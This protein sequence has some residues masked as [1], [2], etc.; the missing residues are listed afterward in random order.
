MVNIAFD[1]WN[2]AWLSCL[3]TNTDDTSSIW[4][5]NHQSSSRLR[6]CHGQIVILK[7]RLTDRSG[8][9]L[10]AAAN[11]AETVSLDCQWNR[12]CNHQ[13]QRQDH[14][15]WPPSSTTPPW[16]E[17]HRIGMANCHKGTGARCESSIVWRERII[18]STAEIIISYNPAPTD[19]VACN[20]SGADQA[21]N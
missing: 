14:H 18:L 21:I 11:C 3:H 7:H 9:W 16:C 2:T 17:W 20:P 19:E 10:E 12:P 13:H 1:M 8:S 4:W 5:Y 15:A 6:N